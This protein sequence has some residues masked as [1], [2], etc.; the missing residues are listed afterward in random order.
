MIVHAALH[1]LMRKSLL[2][3][4]LKL[5]LQFLIMFEK[6]LLL[7]FLLQESLFSIAKGS[8]NN[9]SV[10]YLEEVFLAGW[11]IGSTE[12]FHCLRVGLLLMVTVSIIITSRRVNGLV[13]FPLKYV[14]L[15]KALEVF[16]GENSLR[17]DCLSFTTE[18]VDPDVLIRNLTIIILIHVVSSSLALILSSLVLSY[19]CTGRLIFV[20]VV[21]S[22]C[23]KTIVW[24]DSLQIRHVVSNLEL[25]NGITAHHFGLLYL[26][27]AHNSTGSGILYLWFETEIL[28]FAT[29][30]VINRS[31]SHI[32][33]VYLSEF[34]RS[35][36]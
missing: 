28:S 22:S 18:W 20:C 33:A 30:H 7:L 3:W 26:R 13:H 34:P 35:P 5:S 4:I 11:I 1:V 31:W 14:P 6:R 2:A 32:V 16:H 25:I 19:L 21:H 15:R 10:A 12:A 24:V 9:W 29:F 8:S 27:C 23:F 17:V 36:F